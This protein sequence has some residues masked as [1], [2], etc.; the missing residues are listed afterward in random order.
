MIY[1]SDY[2]QIHQLRYFIA[3]AEELHFGRAANKLNISQPPLS[4]QIIKLEKELNVKLF[5][6]TKRNVE[7]TEV[8]AIFLKDAYEILEQI[9]LSAD[10]VTK[11]TLGEIGEIN[12]GYASYCIFDVLPTILKTFYKKYPEV[13]INLKHLGT[14]EQITAFKESQIDI[15][16]LCPPID[17]AHL[18]LETI[19]NQPF[20]AVLPSE[21]ELAKQSLGESIGIQE[22]S[23]YPFIM[24]P[25]NVGSGYYDKI[26]NICFDANFSPNI[27]LEVNDLHELIS[28][29][30]TGLGVSIVPKSLVQYQK[31]NV[32][33]KKLNHNKYLVDTAIA[34]KTNKKN[35]VINNFLKITRETMDK[36]QSK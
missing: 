6:R 31:S 27:I 30:S 22:L 24:T 36:L 13:K 1:R 32:V 4:Q 17:E 15:G 9:E 8:G 12:L 14:S 29:V 18:T 34:Y 28:L 19:Y 3:V 33:F 10:R 2:L 5:N 20:V 7:L 11:Y 16:L 35:E 26:I 25:R 23:N 21:S